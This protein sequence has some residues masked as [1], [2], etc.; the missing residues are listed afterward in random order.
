MA[1]IHER[2]LQYSEGPFD[3]LTHYLFRYPA[4]FHPPVARELIKQ[5]SQPGDLILDPFCGSGTL[6]VEAATLGRR[7]IGSDI[8]PIAVFVSRVKTHK[9]RT[10]SLLR[11]LEK[12]LGAMKDLERPSS[13]YIKRQ[14]TDLTENEYKEDIRKYG[15]QPPD[16]PNAFHWFRKYVLIDLANI[17]KVIE[18][19][20]APNT[21]RELFQL[22]FARIIRNSSNADPVPVSG[23]EVT[24]YMKKKDEKGRIINPFSLFRRASAQA[25]E[26]VEKFVENRTATSGHIRVRQID[27]TQLHRAITTSVD[28]VITS[29][30]YHNAVDYYRRHTLE[31]YWL[32][33][34]KNQEE[35]LQLLPRY[36]GRSQV[37]KRH[38]FVQEGAVRS[39]TA[40]SWE[41]RIR[42]QSASRADAFKHYM[43]AMQSSMD[44]IAERLPKGKS[45]IL[46]LGK[47]SWNG[48]EIPTVDIF[49]E[50]TQDKYEVV[51]RFWYPLR[52][53]YM[54]YSRH[55]GANINKEY[56][57]V[58]NRT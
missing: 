18:S 21:H 28:V 46:V 17:R 49:R 2:R 44:S 29:P 58:L 36:I 4:K 40:D 56:V 24:S 48:H 45:A 13:E 34:V 23:L 9:F 6:L 7:A 38:P 5:F 35:R 3:R 43:V 12:L 50:I 57:I 51:D 31:M 53:R 30:P 54:T 22:I 8:D 11:S 26:D 14:F 37:P 27:A 47:N 10:P 55:N 1:S 25:L 32:G 16:I 19:A 41:S 42:D 20:D 39:A 15:V 33:F 52:N